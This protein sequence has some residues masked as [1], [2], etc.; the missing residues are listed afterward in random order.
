MAQITQ[1][2]RLALYCK[3]PQRHAGLFDQLPAQPSRLRREHFVFVAGIEF[4]QEM[5]CSFE[6]APEPSK[7]GCFF[8]SKFVLD[9]FDWRER[10]A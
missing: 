1:A 2:A 9:E 3:M 5:E 6:R 8:L 4:A 10:S 7:S